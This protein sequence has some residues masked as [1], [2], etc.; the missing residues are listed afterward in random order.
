MHAT[1]PNT[2][3]LEDAKSPKNMNSDDFEKLRMSAIDELDRTKGA[4]AAKSKQTDTDKEIVKEME[5]EHSFEA[6]E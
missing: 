5:Y 4:L 2:V 3:N 1:R 6:T